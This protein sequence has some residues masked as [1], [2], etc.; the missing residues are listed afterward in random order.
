LLANPQILLGKFTDKNFSCKNVK[1]IKIEALLRYFFWLALPGQ[2]VLNKGLTGW[3]NGAR[4]SHKYIIKL[5][6]FLENLQ[7][8]STL[9]W[10]IPQH[11]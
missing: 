2:A 3:L 6:K 1:I 4:P 5:A 11:K 10:W 7:G 8:I 9:T